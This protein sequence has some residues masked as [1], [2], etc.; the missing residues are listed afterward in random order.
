QVS[1]DLLALVRR[2]VGQSYVS[3]ISSLDNVIIG[4]N[5]SILIPYKP[6]ANPFRYLLYVQTK[7]VAA[8][9]Q[10]RDLNQAR[11][12]VLVD[13]DVHLFQTSQL[14]ACGDQARLDLRIESG[15][16][17]PEPQDEDACK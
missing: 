2:V 1:P 9:R 13:I 11:G 10:V 15:A 16:R 14:N 6:R 7:P 12:N 5:V 3:G 17:R 4:H 8:L